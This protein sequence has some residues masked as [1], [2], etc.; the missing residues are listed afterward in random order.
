MRNVCNECYAYE[1]E[2]FFP[3]IKDTFNLLD[4]DHDGK[5]DKRELETL[6]R[7]TGVLKSDAEMEE[8]LSPVDTDR[9]CDLDWKYCWR[10]RLLCLMEAIIT[11]VL[12]RYLNKRPRILW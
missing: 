4:R 6:L 11:F 3:D 10:D 7:Y 1:C 9:K 5:L 12:H 8:I 2:V